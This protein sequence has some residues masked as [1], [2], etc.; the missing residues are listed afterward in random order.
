VNAVTMH[1]TIKPTS[2]VR[3]EVTARIGCTILR[4]GVTKL[5]AR[6]GRESV[7]ANFGTAG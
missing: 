1:S 5:L 3:K 4:V 7:V 2:F 6:D